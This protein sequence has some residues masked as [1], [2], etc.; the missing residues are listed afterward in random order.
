MNLKNNKKRQRNKKRPINKIYLVGILK[1][2]NKK[3]TP[4]N[5]R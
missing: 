5:K 4:F 3:K 1:Y 2:F